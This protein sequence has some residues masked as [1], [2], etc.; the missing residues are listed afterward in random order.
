METAAKKILTMGCKAVVVKG[1]H[2]IG[3]ASDI[4]YDGK[5]IYHFNSSKIDTKNTHGT[6][7]TFSSAIAAQLATG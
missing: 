2:A 3:D 4:L 7:C 5:T 1:G 6:G